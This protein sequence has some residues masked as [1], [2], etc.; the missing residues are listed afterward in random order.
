MVF[1]TKFWADPFDQLAGTIEI[2]DLDLIL[3]AKPDIWDKLSGNRIFLTGATGFF[4][5]WLLSAFQYAFEKGRFSGSIV[6]LSRNPHLFLHKFPQFQDL[7]FLHFH[8]GDILDFSFPEG[9]FDLVL[10][11]ATEASVQ[12]NLEQPIRMF[13]V[14]ANGT[15]RVLDFCLHSD[16]KRFLLTSSGAVYGQQ[17]AQITHIEETYV[18][19]PNVLEANAA[20]GEGKRVAEMLT[21]FYQRHHGLSGIICRCYAFAGP[22]LPIDSHFAIGNFVRDFGKGGPIKVGGDGSPFRSY[23]Y[24]ADL[25]IWLLT[26]LVN[27]KP[28]EA[29]HVGSDEDL[30]IEQLAHKVANFGTQKLK[31]EIAQPRNPEKALLRYVPSVEKAKRELGLRV[32]TPLEK[33]IGKMVRFYFPEFETELS[34]TNKKTLL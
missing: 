6:A 16:V 30:D 14:A 28:G 24:A 15:R 8:Q 29:Y 1:F 13:D 7:P 22:Y 5:I 32:F 23:L 18:G 17:P 20:Y 33:S 11:A 4:G 9:N 31:V 27:G 21:N 10:H 19:S 12:M 25:V 2:E 26:C 34:I 3:N